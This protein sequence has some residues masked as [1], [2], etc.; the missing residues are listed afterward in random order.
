MSFP[1]GGER[2]RVSAIAFDASARQPDEAI[3]KYRFVERAFYRAAITGEVSSFNGGGGSPL[4]PIQAMTRTTT[5]IF[6]CLIAR[7]GN[8]R[9]DTRF[10]LQCCSTHT[11]CKARSFELRSTS[12]IQTS[13]V[14]RLIRCTGLWNCTPRFSAPLRDI[15]SHM[16][17]AMIQLPTILATVFGHKLSCVGSVIAQARHSDCSRNG[18]HWLT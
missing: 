4:V 12:M 15:T 10:P 14:L 1:S 6:G 8:H 17:K 9:F 13:I 3:L 7:W 11:P 2:R 5:G 16:V 18:R